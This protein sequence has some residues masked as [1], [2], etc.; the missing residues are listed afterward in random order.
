MSVVVH[1]HLGLGDHFICNGLV[2]SLCN[3][4]DKIYLACKKHYYP[5]VK[6]LYQEN[7]QVEVFEIV[8]EPQDIF[9]FAKTNNLPIMHIGFHHC[10]L[11][12]FESSF[13]QQLGLDPAV[14]YSAFRLPALTENG[15][16]MLEQWRSLVGQDYIFVHDQSSMQKFPLHIE[17]S[18]PKYVVEKSQT[19]NVLD[20]IPLMLQA[21]QVHVVNSSIQ[22]L[23]W[24]LLMQARFSQ[25]AIFFHDFSQVYQSQS[26]PIKVPA[27][28]FVHTIKYSHPPRVS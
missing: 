18:L 25:T 1:H 20:Y 2:N 10:D 7:H 22:A 8:Q 4:Y 26:T 14:Q 23:V 5:T 19:T 27:H 9:D 6:C 21:K 11:K 3:V 24:P 12:N 15:L 16:L 13:Y 17:S 28:P